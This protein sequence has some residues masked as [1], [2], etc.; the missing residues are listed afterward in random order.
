MSGVA[1]ATRGRS[2]DID[3]RILDIAAGLFAVHGFDRT[4]VQQV[5]DAAGYSKT[6]LLHRFPSKQAILDAVQELAIRKLDELGSLSAE[7]MSIGSL[8]AASAI[9]EGAL[10][11]PGLVQF[12]VVDMRGST[13]SCGSRSGNHSELTQRGEALIGLLAG[14]NPNPEQEFRTILV[15]EM[16]CNGVVL[17]AT[18]EHGLPRDAVATVLLD[19]VRRLLS[20]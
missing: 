2:A 15:L 17:G 13:A 14:P 3:E 19:A 12:L 20:D 9:I 5:A 8:E 7:A 6:G 1:G 18:E 4:S 11:Y 10:D 16:I